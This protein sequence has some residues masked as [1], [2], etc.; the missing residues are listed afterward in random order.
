MKADN[1]PK[2][3]PCKGCCQPGPP[4][5]AK[6][7]KTRSGA[8]SG[9]VEAVALAGMCK[10]LAHP[11]RVKIVQYLLSIEGCQCSNIVERFELAQ[12]TISQHL[13]VLK[14]AGLVQGQVEGV[15]VCYCLDPA[16]VKQ[17]KQLILDLFSED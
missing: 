1:P 8:G 14:D 2:K 3:D 5:S 12:S 10:A 9:E 15:R 4:Q 7:T 17:L 6:T 13:K 16:A 11:V